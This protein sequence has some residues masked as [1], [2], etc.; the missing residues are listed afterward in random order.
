[1]KDDKTLSNAEIVDIAKKQ[2]FKEARKNNRKPKGVD[3]HRVKRL[4]TFVEW[5]STDQKQ[6]R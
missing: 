5:V 2:D 1:M 3:N 6:R 4:T